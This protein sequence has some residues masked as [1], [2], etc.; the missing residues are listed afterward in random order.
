MLVGGVWRILHDAN[1]HR[2][3]NRHSNRFS[4][5]VIDEA[6]RAFEEDVARVLEDIQL[7]TAAGKSAIRKLSR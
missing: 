7:A 5:V 3:S 6:R 1:V 2:F 4:R